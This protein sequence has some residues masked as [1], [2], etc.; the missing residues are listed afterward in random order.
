MSAIL[1]LLLLKHGVVI[2]T[3]NCVNGS[4]VY[5]LKTESCTIEYAYSEEIIDWIETG[6][7]KYNEDLNLKTNGKSNKEQCK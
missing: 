2:P 6:T 5:N 7:F 3:N 4:P 1:F